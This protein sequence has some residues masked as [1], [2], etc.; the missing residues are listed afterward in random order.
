MNLRSFSTLQI[1]LCVSIAVHAVLLTVRFVDPDSFN[2]VFEVERF[3]TSM[4][5]DVKA[6]T[7]AFGASRPAASNSTEAGRRRNR[8]VELRLC[9]VVPGSSTTPAAPRLRREFEELFG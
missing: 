5:G 7:S 9:R 3:I 6:Q 1:A 4:I 8:R 2:R